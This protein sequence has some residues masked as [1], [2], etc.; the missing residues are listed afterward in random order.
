MLLSL[1]F[2]S[3]AAPLVAEAPLRFATYNAELSRKGPGLLLRD[4]LRGDAAVV[5]AAGLI[6]QRDPDV[7]L[8]TGFDWDLDG[9]ALTAFAGLLAGQGAEYPYQYAPRPNAGV[10]SEFDLDRNGVLGEARD[11]L[12]YGAFSGQGAMALLSKL[13]LLPE[14]ARDFTAL[15]WRDAPGAAPP[16]GYFSDDILAVLPLASVGLWELPLLLPGGGTARVL[17]FYATTPLFDG[18]EDRNGKRNRDE[19]R[20]W[21]EYLKE[22]GQG[23]L[24]QGAAGQG[25]TRQDVVLLTG[26]TQGGAAQGGAAEERVVLNGVAPEN[27]GQDGLAL[28]SE[29][30]GGVA[31]SGAAEE[32]V[33]QAG[34]GVPFVLM[35]D[36]NVDAGRGAGYRSVMAE[37]LRDPALQDVVPE[38]VLGSA[39]VDWGKAGPMRVDYV[40]PSAGWRVLGSGVDWA[41]GGESRHG[42]VWVDLAH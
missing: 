11:S 10:A 16:K 18:E 28:T 8:L 23:A 12:G 7:L 37:L 26:V 15:L 34:A 21:I 24:G 20:F 35:G 25:V 2:L 39:T 38:G 5:A 1:L 30:R 4:I 6:A 9:R 31:Q 14:Q 42:L 41:E 3:L 27:V 32:S 13:P 19:L 29:V 17:A 36:S 40:L 33:A 22:P